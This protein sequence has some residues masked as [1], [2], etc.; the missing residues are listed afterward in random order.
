MP[1]EPTK[2]HTP[3]LT[4]QIANVFL[5]YRGLDALAELTETENAAYDFCRTRTVN[6]LATLQCDHF[7]TI[8][9]LSAC[10][11]EP[12]IL[13]A[14]L[15]LGSAHRAF[16]ERLSISPAT[17]K[18]TFSEAAFN[19]YGNAIKHLRARCTVQDADH[20]RVVLVVC[21]ILI[22]FDLMAQRYQLARVH[23]EHGRR[24]LRL[25]KNKTALIESDTLSSRGVRLFDE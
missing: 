5:F 3:E 6:D 25:L 15:A 20:F 14:A 13:H 19:H 17:E 11:S 1:A 4:T 10:H 12:A 18:G 2:Q 16:A 23:L 8:S 7:W 22:C 21:V 24:I 9:I